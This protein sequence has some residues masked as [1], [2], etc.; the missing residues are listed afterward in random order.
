MVRFSIL[1]LL[2]IGCASA[3]HPGPRVVERVVY[4][5][6]PSAAPVFVE[7][8]G[9]DAC[10]HCPGA[11]GHRHEACDH[12]HHASG[13]RH[14]AS[15]G[16]HHATRRGARSKG[17]ASTKGDGKSK[18][19]AKSKDDARPKHRA[20]DKRPGNHGENSSKWAKARR[21]TP[22]PTFGF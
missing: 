14:H 4:V 15:E 6:T 10:E 2:A 16:G 8:H 13:R 17:E 18:R 5:E 12:D 11:S 7:E 9:H 19:H 22:S 3:S 20:K 1:A 21:K